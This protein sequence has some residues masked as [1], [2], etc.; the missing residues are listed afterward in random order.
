MV[1]GAGFEHDCPY[2]GD[3]NV[4]GGGGQKMYLLDHQFG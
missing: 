4:G 3:K 2:A 1:R